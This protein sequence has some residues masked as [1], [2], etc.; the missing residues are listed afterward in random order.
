[1]LGELWPLHSGLLVKPGKEDIMFVPQKP[2][3]V[4]CESLS[5][6]FLIA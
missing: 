2:Y 3:Q 4:S 1:V 6:T 5:F